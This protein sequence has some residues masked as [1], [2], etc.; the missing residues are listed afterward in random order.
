MAKKLKKPGEYINGLWLVC[1]LA[2]VLLAA[3]L[4]FSLL[5]NVAFVLLGLVAILLVVG[6]F[7]SVFDKK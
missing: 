2:L 1:C 7:L 3:Y 5:W 6:F 4:I